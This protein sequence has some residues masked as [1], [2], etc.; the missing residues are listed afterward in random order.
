MKPEFSRQKN[1]QVSNFMNIRPMEAELFHADRRTDMA[2]LIANFRNITNTPKNLFY[3]PF[4]LSAAL[5]KF[6]AAHCTM[7]KGM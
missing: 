6:P 4:S 1:T 2:K 7:Y 5:A 3:V